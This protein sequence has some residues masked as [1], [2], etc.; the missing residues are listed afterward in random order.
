MRAYVRCQTDSIFGVP[1]WYEREPGITDR[2]TVPGWLTDSLPKNL[3]TISVV[4]GNYLP[5]ACCVF[6]G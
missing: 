2:P 6:R 5:A 1:L 4:I 3:Q